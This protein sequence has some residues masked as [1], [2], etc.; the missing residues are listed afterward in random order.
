MPRGEHV[1]QFGEVLGVRREFESVEEVQRGGGFQV[2]VE[3]VVARPQPEEER[4]VQPS[5]PK[6]SRTWPGA[7]ALKL[8]SPSNE[9]P[10]AY[11]PGV[12]PIPWSR[13]IV[14]PSFARKEPSSSGSALTTQRVPTR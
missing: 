7:S 12:A 8:R 13:W 4:R 9:P 14:P 1:A 6:A 10:L 11:D 2:A 3:I 5:N